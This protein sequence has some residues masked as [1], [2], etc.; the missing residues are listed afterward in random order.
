VIDSIARA[1]APQKASIEPQKAVTGPGAAVA[2]WG[3]PISDVIRD[4]S[5]VLRDALTVYKTNRWIN[6]AEG[7]ISGRVGSVPWHLETDDG[8]EVNDES[9]EEL[10]AVLSLFEKPLRDVELERAYPSQPSTRRTLWGVT[11]RHMGLCNVGFWHLD[12]LSAATDFPLRILYLRP[13]RMTPHFSVN[14]AMDGWT[15][16]KDTRAELVLSLEEVLPFYLDQPDRGYFGVGLPESI[17]STIALPTSIDAHALD[18]LASGGRLPGVYSPKSEAGLSDDVFS[19]LT[20]DLRTIKDMPDSAKRD[21]VAKQPIEFTP[22]AADM[23]SLNVILLS[24]MSRDDTLTHWGVPLSTIGGA[25]PS[26]LNSGEARKFDEAALWQNA[27]GFRIAALRET[28]QYRLLDRLQAIGINLQL[29]IEEPAF[30][31]DS[32]RYET[33]SKAVNLPLTNNERR[34]LVGLPPLEGSIGLE[35]RLP[36]TLQPI[37]DIPEEQDD[38]QE[39]DAAKAALPTDKVAARMERDLRKFLDEQRNE[40]AGKVKAKADAISRKPADTYPWWNGPEWDKRLEKVLRPYASLIADMAAEDV[41]LRLKPTGKAAEFTDLAGNRVFQR[42]LGALGTR[43]KGIN[44]TTREKVSAAIREGLEA[45][46]GAAQL[47]ER[48]EAAA[49]FDEYRAELIARTESARV[50]N[51]SQI[52]SFREYGVTKVRAIDGDD[53]PECAARDGREF[54]VDEALGIADH[55]NGTLDWEPIVGSGKAIMEAPVP[56]K[57]T[58]VFGLPQITI[59]LTVPPTDMQP[60]ADAIRAL[61]DRPNPAPIINVAAAE[62]PATV[63]NVPE[64]AAPIVNV[65]MPEPAQ[66]ATMDGPMDVRVIEMP[67]RVTKARKTVTRDQRGLITTVDETYV[68][69]TS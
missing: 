50:L 34:A 58:A 32:P 3:T 25:V 6:R 52:E 66:K 10:R 13:D 51:E 60:M 9:P 24:Q 48:V 59:P 31:D 4:E 49:A 46:D 26:G 65:T 36:M 45:G 29:V 19:R 5:R 8:E 43:I 12:Q 22:T 62:I 17:W 42:L 23:Q 33:A 44:E 57:P 30:D 11:S 40:I 27:V 47:G 54:D 15:V 21:V 55:P 35:V 41:A 53:D 16:D 64:Q 1:L 69:E 67:D 18:T 2:M 39:V 20:G 56:D 14:G 61:A 28:I 37:G 38:S 68:E 7:V 63:V